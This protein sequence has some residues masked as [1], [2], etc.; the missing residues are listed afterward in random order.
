MGTGEPEPTGRA[1]FYR[2][3]L[4]P[5]SAHNDRGEDV[6]V[7][8]TTADQQ[9]APVGATD[10]R[11]IGL[12][13]N[14]HVLTLRFPQPLNRVEGR[15]LLLIDGWVEYPYSQTVFAAWQAGRNYTAPTLEIRRSD[16]S[17]QTLLQEFGYP[18]GMPRQLAVPLPALPEGTRELRLRTNMEIYWDRIA[19]AYAELPP[20]MQRLNLPLQVARVESLGFPLRSTRAQRV[21]DYDYD[22]RKPYWDTRHAAG[23]YTRFGGATELVADID[24]A[25]AIIGPGESVHLEFKAPDQPPPEGWTRR[26]MLETNGWAKDMD[27]YTRDSTTVEPLPV[28]G[29][30]A[31]KRDA[32]HTRY[33]TR[34]RSGY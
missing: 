12:L 9:A 29:A 3:Q 8:L 34:H 31:A 10:A 14:E 1:L 17:W 16:G 32:L 20:G 11:F 27:M 23:Y 15:S 24:D 33:N 25:V 7:L 21:P 30:N 26:L 22:R 4:L 13:Q 6:T 19:I 28:T 5:T 2:T 18:A